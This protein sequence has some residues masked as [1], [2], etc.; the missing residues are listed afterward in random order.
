MSSTPIGSTSLIT[1]DA[2]MVS[3]KLLSEAS[4]FEQM[5]G[6]FSV[7][8]GYGGQIGNNFSVNYPQKSKSGHFVYTIFG[9]DKEG[10]FEVQRRY[11]EFNLLRTVL[12]QRF[13]G[14]YVPPI[15]PK[16]AV[17]SIT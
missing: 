4:V 3:K 12:T 17:V 14:L 11:K 10:P 6:E 9:Q 13:P 2:S 5:Q 15:P 7:V 8:K 1:K 16:Q